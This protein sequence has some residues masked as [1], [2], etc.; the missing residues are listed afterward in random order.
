M[1][2]ASFVKFSDRV[3]QH[4]LLPVVDRDFGFKRIVLYNEAVGLDAQYDELDKVV[5]RTPQ[6]LST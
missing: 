5:G 2:R 1:C 6:V 3:I 4:L